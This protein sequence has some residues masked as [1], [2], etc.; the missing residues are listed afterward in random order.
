[1][2]LDSMTSRSAAEESVGFWEKYNIF[3]FARGIQ[4][5]K[6]KQPLPRR[7]ARRTA[8]YSSPPP[9]ASETDVTIVVSV[10]VRK[11]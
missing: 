1:M 3:L 8:K 6:P 7:E 11:E 9:S 10:L 2:M 5:N 4:V